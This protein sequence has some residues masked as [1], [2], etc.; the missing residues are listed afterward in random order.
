M[1]EEM[2]A[3]LEQQSR[4][5]GKMVEKQPSPWE[6]ILDIFCKG[7]ADMESTMD[8]SELRETPLRCTSPT[9]LVDDPKRQ[10]S[11]LNGV[12]G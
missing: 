3:R 10:S 9:L 8:S 6:A 7:L 12:G 2:L 5:E 4:E 1:A 11:A